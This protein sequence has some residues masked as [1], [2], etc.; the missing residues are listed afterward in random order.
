MPG[1]SREKHFTPPLVWAVLQASPRGAI[2]DR[3]EMR[4]W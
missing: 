1:E 2:S 3:M 4:V